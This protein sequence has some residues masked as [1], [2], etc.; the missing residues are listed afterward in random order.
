MVYGVSSAACRSWQ[1]FCMP[2]RNE[3]P[4]A[5]NQYAFCEA[6]ENMGCEGRILYR[7]PD[8]RND[9]DLSCSPWDQQ[10]SVPAVWDTHDKR[11][12]SHWNSGGSS[13]GGDSDHCIGMADS[14]LDVLLSEDWICTDFPDGNGSKCAS[15]NLGSIEKYL[16]AGSVFFWTAADVSGSENSAEW[17]SRGTGERD[18]PPGSAVAVGHIAGNRNLNRTILEYKHRNSSVVS[19][20][21]GNRMGKIRA[22][23]LKY[24]RTVL[25]WMHLGIPI[26]GAGIFLLYGRISGI[27]AWSKLSLYAETLAIVFP[28]VSAVVCALAA[29]Q[30]KQAG[31]LY[32]VLCMPGRKWKGMGIKYLVLCGLGFAAL[33]LALGLYG[34]GAA[35]GMIQPAGG[36]RLYLCLAGVLMLSQLVLYAWHL[37]LAVQFTNGVCIG[38]GITESLLAALLMTGLG[39]GI[40]YWIPCSWGG[41]FTEYLIQYQAGSGAAEGIRNFIRQDAPRAAGMAV[42]LTAAGLLAGLIWCFC[43]EGGSIED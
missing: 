31:N 42:I 32:H 9:M 36:V 21:G 13:G 39:D 5:G 1:Y 38:I 19:K 7:N 11:G 33:V 37:V 16:V 2:E 35:A 6:G 41:H 34:A 8:G 25:L 15:G 28:A 14:A 20:K 17:A 12:S 22:E 4:A 18:V 29:E 24:Q 27:G 23:L 30:E 40:W 3:K 26:L 10:G 43:F